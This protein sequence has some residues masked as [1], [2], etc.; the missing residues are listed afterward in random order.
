MIPGKEGRYDA[1]ASLYSCPEKEPDVVFYDF[2]YFL[3]EYTQNGESRYFSKTQL[4][5]H[6]FHGC[7]HKCSD[8]KSYLDL[9]SFIRQF[10]NNFIHFFNALKVQAS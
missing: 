10:V 5:H 8:V 3:L 2:A 1:S 7:T 4:L 6:I 9:K